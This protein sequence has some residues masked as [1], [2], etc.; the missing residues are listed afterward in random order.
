M[1]LTEAA[2]S[3][4][5][6]GCTRHAGELNGK[7]GVSTTRSGKSSGHRTA[8]T[9]AAGSALTEAQLKDRGITPHATGAA[10]GVVFHPIPAGMATGAGSF[11]RKGRCRMIL[12]IVLDSRE[13]QRRL[14]EVAAA[15]ASP[16]L[17]REIA[18]FWKPRLKPTSRRKAFLSHPK[19]LPPDDRQG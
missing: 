1:T 19:F 15:L 5:F 16:T 17:M 2:R 14:G 11:A 7:V 8:S 6:M 12:R 18:A 9:A 4:V 10:R 3:A 13:V